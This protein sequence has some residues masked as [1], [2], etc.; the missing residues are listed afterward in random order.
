[1]EVAKRA[2]FSVSLSVRFCRESASP[3]LRLGVIYNFSHIQIVVLRPF[4][5]PTPRRIR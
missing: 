5:S 3:D 2:L 4:L 1:M